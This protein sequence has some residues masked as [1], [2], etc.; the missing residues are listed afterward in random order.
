LSLY[1]KLQELMFGKVYSVSILH[2]NCMWRWLMYRVDLD[3]RD[4][5]YTVS[6]NL[7]PIPLHC[8]A[9]FRN[10]YSFRSRLLCDADVPDRPCGDAQTQTARTCAQTSIPVTK[11]RSSQ[12]NQL[13]ARLS[14]NCHLLI[15]HSND[16]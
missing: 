10:L 9:T 15:L 13:V 16:P 11:W 5:F 4:V 12:L 1:D 3:K 7:P 14:I 8:L 6:R 2:L